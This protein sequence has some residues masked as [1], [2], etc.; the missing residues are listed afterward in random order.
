MNYEY[1]KIVE[2]QK[3]PEELIE[4]TREKMKQMERKKKIKKYTVVLT[5]AACFGIVCIAGIQMVNRSSASVYE[6]LEAENIKEDKFET[7]LLLG[8]GFSKEEKN[9]E[10]AFCVMK[11]KNTEELPEEVWKLKEQ[12]IKREKIRFGYYEEKKMYCALFKREN[13]FV[14]ITGENVTEQ[15]MKKFLD[16]NF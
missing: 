9:Y 13:V 4:K 16:K 2:R 8:K 7:G 3:A 1:K 10:S 12:K 6:K 5:T 14:Y 15:E 11:Y